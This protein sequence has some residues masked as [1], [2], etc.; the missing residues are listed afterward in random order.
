MLFLLINSGEAFGCSDI[1]I[2]T[3]RYILIW[4][5]RQVLGF[6]KT[7][8]LTTYLRIQDTFK[9]Y[10]YFER[11]NMKVLDDQVRDENIPIRRRSHSNPERMS[12]TRQK[13]L[14]PLK[15]F[16]SNI[17]RITEITENIRQFTNI[18]RRHSGGLAIS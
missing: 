13:L 12:E 1:L 8:L 3:G 5:Y 14:T 6:G 15:L 18:G 16:A 17:F 2:I 10:E 9:T 11:T 7:V 4:Q